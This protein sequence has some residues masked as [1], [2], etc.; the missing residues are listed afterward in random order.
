MPVRKS[1]ALQI[2]TPGRHASLYFRS[3]EI[4]VYPDVAAQLLRSHP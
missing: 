4:A 3:H 2:N 1:N